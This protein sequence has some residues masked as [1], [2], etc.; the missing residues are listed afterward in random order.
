MFQKKAQMRTHGIGMGK[1]LLCLFIWLDRCLF[2][3]ILIDQKVLI[4]ILITAPI[5]ERTGCKML[6]YGR[7]KAL[8]DML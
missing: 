2:F 8:Q 3:F 7:N 6:W 5:K 1:E 4:T